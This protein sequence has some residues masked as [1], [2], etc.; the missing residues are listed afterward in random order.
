MSTTTTTGGTDRKRVELTPA[1]QWVLHHLMLEQLDRAREEYDSTPWWAVDVVEK[2]ER[3]ELSFS[4]FEAWRLRRDLE[5][6]LEEGPDRD[7]EEVES[8]LTVLERSFESPPAS[9]R[10]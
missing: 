6:Y 2:L 8:I 9:L 5:R 3:G 10:E 4:T 7:A 1:E